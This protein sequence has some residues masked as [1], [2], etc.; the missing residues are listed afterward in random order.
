[1]IEAQQ[2]CFF[3]RKEKETW[4]SYEGDGSNDRVALVYNLVTTKIRDV[5]TIEKKIIFLEIFD[6]K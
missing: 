1:M 5:Y 4:H 3:S 2:G 6:L